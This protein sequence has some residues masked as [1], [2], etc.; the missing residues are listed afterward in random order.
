MPV[1]KKTLHAVAA[2]AQVAPVPVFRSPRL[3][4]G[5]QREVSILSPGTVATL[6]W[7]Q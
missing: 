7:F 4:L 3:S 6:W 1:E 2:V 5:V